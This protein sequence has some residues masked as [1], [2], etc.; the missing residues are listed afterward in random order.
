MNRNIFEKEA[1]IVKALAHAGRLEIIH[2]LR[3]HTLTVSQITQMLGERQAYVSQ[4]L[5]TLKD[6]GIVDA[7]RSGK[8]MYYELSDP[9]ITMACDSL[10]SLVS[11]SPIAPSP[12][13]TVI[14][15]ICHMKLKP[16]VTHLTSEYNGVRHYFCGQGC[17]QEFNSLHKG[18]I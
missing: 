17:L 12:E 10:H 6:A 11:A 15:P 13:P 3:H 5:M 18:A 16:S 7:S 2:L 9:R 4:Q 1:A 14:D 8:E